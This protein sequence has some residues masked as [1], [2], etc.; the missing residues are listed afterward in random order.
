[1]NHRGI[2]YEI[3]LAPASNGWIW[4]IHTPTP[5][6]GTVTGDRTRAVTAALSAIEDYCRQYPA[7]CMAETPV[8]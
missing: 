4:L 2:R 5:K 6:Q 8:A 7:E 3:K 1:M